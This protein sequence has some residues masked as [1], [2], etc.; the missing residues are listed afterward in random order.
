VILLLG[1]AYGRAPR[2]AILSRAV[3][4]EAGELQLVM[5]YFLTAENGYI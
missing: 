4:R 3:V 2:R 1:F 5:R